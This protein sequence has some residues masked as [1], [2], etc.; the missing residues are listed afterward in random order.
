MNFQAH[1][2]RERILDHVVGGPRYLQGDN[3]SEFVA[4]D[5]TTSVQKQ[6]IDPS[7]IDPGKPWPNSSNESINSP[8][9]REGLDVELFHTLDE[10]SVGPETRKNWILSVAPTVCLEIT[11]LR[12]CL[13]ES[14]PGKANI[15]SGSRAGEGQDG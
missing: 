9:R 2:S 8:L 14:S 5:L 7:R 13:R 15:S 3:R 1:V 6:A 12:R 11:S 10:T 4:P